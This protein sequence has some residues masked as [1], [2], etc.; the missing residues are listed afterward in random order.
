MATWPITLPALWHADSFQ[1]SDA[2]NLI[3][4]PVDMGPA[5]RRRR[6]T[7][8]ERFVQ[9]TIHL[10]N[11]QYT[12]LRNFYAQ[13]CAHGAISFTRLDA[14][15]VSRTFYFERPPQYEYVAYDWWN[16]TLT[17]SERY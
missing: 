17:L 3:R 5:K 6:T 15:G 12:I 1:E 14:H 13:D 10:T 8:A 2:D 11:A 7:A 4:S 16:A 9:N